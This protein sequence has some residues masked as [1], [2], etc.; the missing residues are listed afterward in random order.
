MNCNRARS[1]RAPL[2]HG[3]TLIELIVTMFVAAV[4]LAI[5][6]PS[7]KHLISNTH[8]GSVSNDFLSTLKYARTEAVSRGNQVAVSA[9]TSGEWRDGWSAVAI[10]ANA[11]DSDSLL[12]KHD[13]LKA[14]YTI[15]VT[16]DSTTR[17][18]FN[19]RGSTT[20]DEETCFTLRPTDASAQTPPIHIAILPSGA[21]HSASQCTTTP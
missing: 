17:V 9:S 14:R 16:P 12:R 2:A 21:I 15:T 13:A 18:A 20:A 7:F 10:A 1:T 6:V 19:S 5:A 3:F 8:L 4:L 11:D